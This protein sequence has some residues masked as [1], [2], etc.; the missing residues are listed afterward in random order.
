LKSY[1]L[2]VHL[3]HICSKYLTASLPSPCMAHP[4]SMVLPVT[5]FQNG[6]LLNTLP[7]SSML[8]HFA[9]VVIVCLKKMARFDLKVWNFMKKKTFFFLF[10]LEW[11]SYFSHVFV[12]VRACVRACVRIR[13][14]FDWQVRFYQRVLTFWSCWEAN[15]F[16]SGVVKAWARPSPMP[17]LYLVHPSYFGVWN[18][19]LVWCLELGSKAIRRKQRER[20]REKRWR[21]S[22]P[23]GSH[24]GRFIPSNKLRRWRLEKGRWNQGIKGFLCCLDLIYRQWVKIKEL[25]LWAR[26]GV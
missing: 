15:A 18:Y 4:P 13:V 9:Y 16:D 24:F 6:I 12:C 25:Y 8:P 26:R 3:L 1:H 14:L 22:F 2:A 7:A 10:I 23:W 20:K 11:D 21:N 17:A 19:G 5:T